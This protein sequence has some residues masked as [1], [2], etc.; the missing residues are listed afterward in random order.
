M[1]AAR[2]SSPSPLAMTEI[3]TFHRPPARPLFGR[4]PPAVFTVGCALGAIWPGHGGQ[5]FGIGALVG[6]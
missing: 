3:V 1:I 2:E 6:V 4:L 5:L